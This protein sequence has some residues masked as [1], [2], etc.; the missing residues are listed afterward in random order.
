M[1][2]ILKTAI[3]LDISDHT[4]E[5]VEIKKN[6]KQ[7]EIVSMGR[8]ALPPG[9]VENG[10]IKD[11]E[12]LAHIVRSLFA[13]ARPKPITKK[14]IIFGLSESQV[15]IHAFRLKELKDKEIL[16]AL[17]RAMQ[18]VIPI[19]QEEL[20]YSHT[21]LQKTKTFRDVLVVATSREVIVEWGAFFKKLGLSVEAFDVESLAVFRDLYTQPLKKPVCVV[22]I[23]SNTTMVSIFDGFGLQYSRV[24]HVAGD[25][26]DTVLVAAGVKSV[27]EA[28][29]MKKDFG[30]QQKDKK[31]RT[32]IQ[33]IV[34][35]MVDDIAETISFVEI[36][37]EFTV[38]EV[39]LVGGG[40]QLKGLFDHMKKVLSVPVRQGSSVLLEKKSP[41]HYLEAVGLAWRGVDSVWNKKDPALPVVLKQE[42]KKKAPRK[43]HTKEGA[44]PSSAVQEQGEQGGE[45]TTKLLVILITILVVGGGALFGAFRYRSNA[46]EVKQ[47]EVDKLKA[48]STVI[49][50]NATDIAPVTTS[51]SDIASA[52]STTPI[53]VTSTFAEIEEPPQ[54]VRYVKVGLTE[55]GSLNIRT[56]PGTGFGIVTSA[57]QGRIFELIEENDVSG[58]SHLRVSAS[59]TGW[60]ASRY[61]GAE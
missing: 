21:F 35:K 16:K 48:V 43:S 58:W 7:A 29:K 10:R 1:F 25:R 41:L 57:P 8:A 33:G 28:E 60:A 40:S 13:K 44:L 52:V 38:G 12:Q 2:R 5:V 18:S 42:K 39:V 61:L 23:G 24:S 32:A 49:D 51:T 31:A 36:K 14:R 47:A 56:G 55:T 53:A 26:I 19:A 54:V 22:D 15:H 37:K 9:V 45:S 27:A 30:M 50:T 59:T 20:V 34:E 46:R 3:G 6:G 17:P 4:I 11:E